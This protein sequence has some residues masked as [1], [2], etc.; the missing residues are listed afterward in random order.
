MT[1]HARLQ[2]LPIAFFSAVMGL[3]GLAIALQ[4]AGSLW[5]PLIALGD[6]VA[7]SAALTFGLLALLYALKLA[8][9]PAEVRAEL[10]DPVKMSFG[11]TVTVSLILLGITTLQMAPTVSRAL[12]MISAALHLVYTLYAVNSWLYRSG[13]DIQH[14]SPAWFR[15][16]ASSMPVRT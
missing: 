14:I 11:A 10:S 2:Y 1:A 8:R 15:W 4:S 5:A 12:W 16:L 6:G 7:L 3:C 9:H 13:I